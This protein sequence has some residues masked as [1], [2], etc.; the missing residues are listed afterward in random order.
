MNG[1]K[2]ILG[3]DYRKIAKALV[4]RA[5]L[6][7]REIRFTL[8]FRKTITI[9]GEH[10]VPDAMQ[11]ALL[12]QRRHTTRKRGIQYAAASRSITDAPDTGSP[13]GACHRAA[14]C[15]DPVAGDDG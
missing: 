9:G 13:A 4:S 1:F 8:S 5:L 2:R 14:R 15:A 10:R 12:R 6:R 3:A 11:C 7:K